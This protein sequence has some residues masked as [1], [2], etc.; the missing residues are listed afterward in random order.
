M[1]LTG[2]IKSIGQTESFGTNNFQKRELVITTEE[3]YPQH[4]LIEFVQDKCALLDNLMEGHFVTVG[5]NIRGREW[6]SPIGKTK[7]F[8]T[9]Q[10]WKIDRN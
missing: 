8:N 6:V 4:V 2:T 5:I 3:Q 9:I 7:Y 10:G 1:T